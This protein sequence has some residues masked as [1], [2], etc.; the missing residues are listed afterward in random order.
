MGNRLE[1]GAAVIATAV[2]TLPGAP[3]VYRMLSAEGDALY[4]GKAKN[5][6]KRVNSYTGVGKLPYRLKRMVSETVSME[7]VT[8][9]TEVEALLLESNLIKRLM[10]RYNVLLRDDKSFPYIF[11]TADRETA[12]ITKHRG[13]QKRD[14]DY[15]GPFADA[16]AV[17][18]TITALEKA[19]LLRSCSDGVFNNRK[20]PCLLYQ[21]KRCS[22]PCVDRITPEA[23]GELVDQARAFLSGRS[24]RVQQD[25]VK[26]MEA[27]SEAM[28]FEVAAEYRDRIRALAHIQSRQDVNVAGIDDAD[29]FAAHADAGQICIQVFFF[30]AGRNYGNRAY[31]PS[32]DKTLEIGAVLSSFLSQ[33]YDNKPIPKLILTS[34]QP[35]DL[36]LL[37][38]ALSFRSEHRVEIAT[39]LRGAKRKIIENALKNAQQALAR[40]LAESGSQRRLLEGLAEALGLESTPERVEVYDNSHTQGSNAYGGMIVAGLEGFLKSSYRKFS[41]RGAANSPAKTPEASSGTEEESVENEKASLGGAVESQN[42]EAFTPGDDYA[43]MREV[44]HR[45]LTRVMK[46]DPERRS[47]QW[48]DLILLDGGKGQLTVGLEVLDELG[49]DDIAI[50]AVAKGPERNAGRE[51]IFLPNKPSFMLGPRDPVLYFIQR[52]R[53]EAH[54]FAIE[55]HRKGRTKSRLRSVLDDVPGIGAKRKKALLLHF[56]SAGA[57]SRA[58]LSDLEAVEGINKAVAR[59]IYD[60][61]N[62]LG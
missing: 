59:K 18:M 53:D 11:V 32:H 9:H 61:F 19:F 54:R 14:G 55:T 30:R 1:R 52:L 16:K 13:A 60:H 33:F 4:V 38:E 6:K 56:G 57:V 47:D 20:R 24:Q 48:P 58:G 49:I 41:I 39:P 37:S 35:T 29:I 43:M 5:L 46:E 2:K 12:Q 26:Q 50:A 40:R 25:L 28:H 17:N 23:Y 36:K 22:A 15:F 31:F 51:R 8:T 10:P 44:L 7:F 3:G 34:H 27:A 45:R 21:I 42:L 62:T